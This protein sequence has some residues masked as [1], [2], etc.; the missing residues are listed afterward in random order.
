MNSKGTT[1]T[2]FASLSQIMLK[3]KVPQANEKEM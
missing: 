3:E 1:L 2:E